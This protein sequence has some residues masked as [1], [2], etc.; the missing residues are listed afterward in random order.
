M[1]IPVTI[2]CDIEN[3][4]DELIITLP[5]LTEKVKVIIGDFEEW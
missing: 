4:K 1:K 3:K 5:N 2:I